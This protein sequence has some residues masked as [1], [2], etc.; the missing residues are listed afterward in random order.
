M[1]SVNSGWLPYVLASLY[2]VALIS[3]NLAIFRWGCGFAQLVA[4][5]GL[6]SPFVGRKWFWRSARIG[7]L[8]YYLVTVG[9]NATGLYIAPWW[10]CRAG[11]PPI[12]IPWPELQVEE[13]QRW[14]LSQD[15]QLY[16]VAMP[17]VKIRLSQRLFK[18]LAMASDGQLSLPPQV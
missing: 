14:W 11:H 9:L 18:K 13:P 3:T 10:P 2:G 4:H 6:R 12:L 5:Y 17:Q 15:Y 8:G 1:K 7:R 16:A